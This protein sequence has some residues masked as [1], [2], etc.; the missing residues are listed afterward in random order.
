MKYLTYTLILQMCLLMSCKAQSTARIDIEL[1]KEEQ[2][3]AYWYDGKAEIT[4]YELVQ[5]RYGQSHDGEAVMIYVTE[6]FSRSKQV[7]LDNPRTSDKVSVLKLNHTRNFLTGIYPYT[8]MTSAFKPMDSYED[9]RV[10]KIAT[11]IQEWCG[12]TYMQINHR[13]S[14]YEVLQRSYFESEGDQE[15]RVDDAYTEE[16]IFLTVR[17]NPAQLP[18]GRVEL[19]P[20]T[21]STRLFH[22]SYKPLSALASA[23]KEG[24]I[25]TY[26]VDYQDVNRKLEI[27]FEAAYPWRILQWSEETGRGKTVA[28]RMEE[29]KID[30]WSHNQPMDEQLRT[31]LRLK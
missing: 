14:K 15:Y 22:T 13:S 6:D 20:A 11:S 1:P 12:H 23:K 30:Y 8:T 3:N 16:E 24:N 19:L 18:L 29:L 28:K 17:I 5:S 10:M 9:Q 4:S 26:R 25:W 2:R 7:K 27:Q 21:L 31:Q